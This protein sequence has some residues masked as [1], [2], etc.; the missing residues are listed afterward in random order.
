MSFPSHPRLLLTLDIL[1]FITVWS[2][3]EFSDYLREH[4]ATFL[5]CASN[6]QSQNR[7]G[8]WQTCLRSLILWSLMNRLAVLRSTE[9]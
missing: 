2:C 3:K 4:N 9:V 6:D 1:Q 5:C 7:V 8:E